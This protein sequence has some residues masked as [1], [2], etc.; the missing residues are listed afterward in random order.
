MVYLIR[1]EHFNAAHRIYNDDWS[2]E[3]NSE[4]FGKCANKNF[5]GH[6]YVLYVT[7]RGEPKDETGFI[8]DAHKLSLIIKKHVLNKVDHMNLNMDVDFLKGKHTS[9]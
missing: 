3:K 1:R 6:N 4:V 5:H 7:V 2:D 8:M 9:T